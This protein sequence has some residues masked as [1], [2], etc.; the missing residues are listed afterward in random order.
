MGIGT[1][2]SSALKIYNYK[3]SQANEKK[4]KD[5]AYTT[6]FYNSQK[7]SQICE[8]A[9]R[10]VRSA[11][12]GSYLAGRGAVDDGARWAGRPR[13]VVCCW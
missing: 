11:H 8:A 3:Q 5:W 1:L 2:C 9:I 13:V 6:I 10:A 7:I 4:H 12:V